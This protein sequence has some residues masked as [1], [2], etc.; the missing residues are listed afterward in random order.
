VEHVDVEGR[1]ITFRR[2][3]SGPPLIFLHGAVCDSRV[4]R[5]HLEAFADE[6]TV[7]AWDAPGCGQS[8]DVPDDSGM[9]TYA[10]CLAGALSALGLGASHVVGHSWGSTLALQLCLD[11][12]HFVRSLVLV[13]AYAGWAGS[14]PREE[15]AARLEFA[16]HVA[17][18]DPRSF[19]PHTMKGIFSDVMSDGTDDELVRIMREI[20][21]AATR[22]M[23]DALAASDL[24]DDLVRIAVPTMV[25]AGGADERS[26]LAVAQELH[27]RIAGSTLTVLPGLGHECPLESP[28]AFNAALRGFLTSLRTSS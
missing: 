20:R 13:G 25:L 2:V 28:A 12:P 4:W 14:L 21:P 22:T 23:A 1:R 24:R 17:D 7:L 27:R 6:F 26:P 16:H 15:V 11:H 18:L 3:G 9:D 19:D 10:D 5:D 8:D